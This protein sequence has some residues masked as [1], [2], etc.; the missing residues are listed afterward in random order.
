ML[1]K[2][3]FVLCLLLRKGK[4]WLEYFESE[5]KFCLKGLLK[6]VIYLVS[7]LNIVKK[8]DFKYKLVFVLYI[9][10]DVFGLIVELEDELNVW[11]KI[12]NIEKRKDEIFNVFG[13]WFIWW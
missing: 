8:E 9:W 3:F 4:F 6:W 13:K 1:K 5:K 11:M 7:C 10:E 2:W 12:M